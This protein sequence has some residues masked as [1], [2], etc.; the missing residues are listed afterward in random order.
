[1]SLFFLSIEKKKIP[2]LEAVTSSLS[3]C[4]GEWDVLGSI[5]KKVW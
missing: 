5:A 1:V 4:P 2:I 3:G